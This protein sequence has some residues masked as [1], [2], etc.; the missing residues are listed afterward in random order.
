MRKIKYL[1]FAAL[2]ILSSSFIPSSNGYPEDY[3]TVGSRDLNG[4]SYKTLTLKRGESGKRIKAK[5]FASKD[6]SG[7]SVPERYKSWSYSKKIIAVTSGTYMS[8]LNADYGKPKGLTI[9]NGTVVN[10]NL[11]DWDGLVIVYATGG[12]V[13]SNLKEKNL[14]VQGGSIGGKKLDIQGNYFD[15]ANFITW[16]QDNKATVF[17]TH[18]LAFNNNLLVGSNCKDNP[19]ERRFLAVGYDED[20]KLVHII[21]NAPEAANLYNSSKRVMSFLQETYYMNIEWMVNLDTGAQDVFKLYN[22]DGTL[23]K[24]IHGRMDISNADNL[25]VYYYE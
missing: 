18:L 15:K 25:L 8:D 1:L 16:C 20:G 3:V 5:Y 24:Y 2:I 14:V 7:K 10:K 17:Q 21:V 19:R 13:A 4:Y 23:N 11:E 9:D 12:V 6:H 22:S